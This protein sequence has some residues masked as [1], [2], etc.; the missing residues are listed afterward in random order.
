MRK[1]R[2]Q[3][4]A[5][6]KQNRAAGKCFGYISLLVALAVIFICTTDGRAAMYMCKDARGR[7]SFTNVLASAGCTVFALKKGRS[8]SLGSNG[9]G[10]YDSRVYDKDIASVSRRY[11][12]DQ[13]LIKAIISTE[14]AFNHRA[15]SRRGA[16]GL[17]QLMPATARE[18]RVYNP[19]NPQENIDGGTRYFKSLLKTF[20][21]DVKLS[22]AA[23]NAGPGQVLR[24]N[25]I[26]PIPET[27]RYVKKV[28]RQYRIYKNG[29]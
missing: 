20:G 27:V 22:L 21:G 3:S 19:F 28:L 29:G 18:L 26:P 1:Y 11:N 15:V 9:G 24:A 13:H 25:G 5:P 10:V 23:Y 6:E 8:V 7:V 4:S 14:S 12:V 16:K 17:M 2:K